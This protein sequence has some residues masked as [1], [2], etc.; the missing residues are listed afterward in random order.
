MGDRPAS[1]SRPVP[2]GPWSYLGWLVARQ[3]G[4]VTLGAAL[5]S[6]WMAG[7]AVPPYLLSRAVDGLADGR[8]GTVL[9]WAALPVV[10]GGVLAG[11]SI[12]RHRTMTRGRMDAA[13][14]TMSQ[15][16]AHTV[17][18]G[19]TLTRR[20]R[21]G[22]IVAIGSGDAWVIGRSLIATGSGVGAVLAYIVIAVL[23]LRISVLLAV[24]VLAPLH[25]GR[26]VEHSQDRP[27]MRR[28]SRCPSSWMSTRGCR[29]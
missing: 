6:A 14:H 20:V 4:R 2:R 27:R 28:R 16:S 23:L 8:R 22:E 26:R 12:W 17:H 7:L 11:L 29:E 25:C 13:F 21:T 3:R 19:A 24:V 10:A 15:V 1:P 18:L 5:G 9:V